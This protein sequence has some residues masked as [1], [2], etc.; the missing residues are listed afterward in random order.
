LRRYSGEE[1]SNKEKRKAGKIAEGDNLEARKP[2]RGT[3]NELNQEKRNLGKRALI[4]C[5]CSW[6]PGFQISSAV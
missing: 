4:S 1:E 6:L 3:T 5:F 2:G